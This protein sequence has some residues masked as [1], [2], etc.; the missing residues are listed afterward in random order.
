[1]LGSEYNIT[2][3][4]NTKMVEKG[5][6]YL[7]GVKKHSPKEKPFILDHE[8]LYLPWKGKRT[9][10]RRASAYKKAGFM[11]DRGEPGNRSILCSVNGWIDLGT[12]QAL[13]HGYRDLE[14]M[15]RIWVL[16]F[17]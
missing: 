7:G 6:T 8:E 10:S 11:E 4:L 14:T 1:M 13:A 16:I 12:M 3:H 2:T 15:L 9:H 17:F 5:M